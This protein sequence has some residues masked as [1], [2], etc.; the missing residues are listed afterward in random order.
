MYDPERM[1]LVPRVELALALMRLSCEQFWVLVSLLAAYLLFREP[2]AT[3]RFVIYLNSCISQGIQTVRRRS[4]RF[5]HWRPHPVRRMF[6][7]ASHMRCA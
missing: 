2:P 6:S 5:L 1:E 7:A 4:C 3:A